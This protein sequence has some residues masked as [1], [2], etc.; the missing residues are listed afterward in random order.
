M[1]RFGLPVGGPKNKTPAG[2]SR[3]RGF[4]GIRLVSLPDFAHPSGARAYYYDYAYYSAYYAND[5]RAR[6]GPGGQRVAAVEVGEVVHGADKGFAVEGGKKS[7]GK[8]F[9]CHCSG[10]NDPT[11]MQKFRWGMQQEIHS[12]C[13]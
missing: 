3:R 11:I 9:F 1:I 6:A 10:K 7:A 5:G 4:C 2:L 12:F 13:G 8:K